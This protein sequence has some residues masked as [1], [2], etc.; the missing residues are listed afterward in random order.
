MMGILSIKK[1]LCLPGLVSCRPQVV[2][3]LIDM[4][5]QSDVRDIDTPRDSEFA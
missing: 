2:H 5:S 4:L 1:R 3:Q